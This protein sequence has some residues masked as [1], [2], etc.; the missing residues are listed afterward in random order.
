MYAPHSHR[1]VP[2]DECLIENRQAKAVIL[3]VRDLMVRFGVLPYDEDAHA[4]FLRHAVVRV[5]HESGEVLVTLVTNGREF[6]GSRAFCRELVRRR[7][8]VITVVQNVNT[9]QTNVILGEE[10]RTLFGP[11]FILDRLCGLSFRISSRS[12][13]QVNS[14]QT[15][16]LYPCHWPCAPDGHGN[17]HRRLLRHGHH[18][19]GG[20]EERR[21]AG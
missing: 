5:G 18:R 15:E 4:G 19:P 20:G 21:G 1:L 13:Y 6:P 9:R 12:F 7:P 8:F 14:V 16:V 3:A 11:G 2:T 10:E 17:G